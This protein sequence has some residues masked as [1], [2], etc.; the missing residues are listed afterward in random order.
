MRVLDMSSKNSQ[1]PK[2]ARA[3][4]ETSD[5]AF[6]GGRVRVYQPRSGFRSGLDAVMLAAAVPAKANERICD[7]GAGVGTAALCL[8]ARVPGLHVA[9]IEL[10]P[11][12]AGLA[13]LNFERNAVAE[14]FE[15]IVADVLERPR[16]IARQAYHHVLTN[17]PF[18]DAA[19]GTAAP[20]PDKARATSLTGSQLGVWLRFASSLVRPKG[21]L[22]AILPPA[23][24]PLALDA[25]SPEGLGVEIIPLWPSIDVAAKRVILRARTNSKT[26]L[27]LLPGL[28]LFEPGGAP[29][30]A[31]EAILRHGQALST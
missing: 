15:C 29:A 8:A 11:Q 28:T 10:N 25:I 2:A 5:D 12:F 27:R 7:V 9:V 21:T 17:P 20:Q 31:A 1:R 24:I 3:A 14:S 26:P 4:L 30:K 23:Q 22:T 13:R 18:H 6:L 19:R 16:T